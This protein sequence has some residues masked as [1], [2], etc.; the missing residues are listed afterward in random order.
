[1]RQPS[2]WL[3]SRC[4]SAGGT[5]D[6]EVKVARL[7]ALR[8]CTGSKSLSCLNVHDNVTLYVHRRSLAFALNVPAIGTR[9]VAAAA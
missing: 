3:C 8:R 5:L 4:R 2:R 6:M 7:I 9:V 1:M